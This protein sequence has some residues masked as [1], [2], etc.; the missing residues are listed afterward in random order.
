[1]RTAE[2]PGTPWMQ[3]MYGS[4]RRFRTR[5]G[6]DW[7]LHQQLCTMK[8]GMALC[9][10]DGVPCGILKGLLLLAGSAWDRASTNGNV[11]PELPGSV[12]HAPS[13][14]V[15][16]Q[17]LSTQTQQ[18]DE[19]TFLANAHDRPGAR[20]AAFSLTTQPVATPTNQP[21]T[22]HA[23]WGMSRSTYHACLLR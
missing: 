7:V 10:P 4:P 15:T 8:A 2:A 16:R 1:M 13:R 9:F 11:R 22:V 5:S 6:V 19:L 14:P 3:A 23:A 18:A 17:H 21:V 12:H 20:S